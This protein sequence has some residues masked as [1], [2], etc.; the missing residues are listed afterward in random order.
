MAGNTLETAARAT[1][2][3]ITTTTMT[4]V[5]KSIK[6]GPLITH[7]KV[8]KLNTQ[9]GEGK[10]GK[11]C[12][13]FDIFNV[14]AKSKISFQSIRHYARYIWEVAFSEGGGKGEHPKSV[15]EL[16]RLEKKRFVR[17]LLLHKHNS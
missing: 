5:L 7:L 16:L 8:K 14:M 11:K 2:T 9:L 13:Q 12:D 6:K 17:C 4:Y 1:E 3:K 15:T 10:R